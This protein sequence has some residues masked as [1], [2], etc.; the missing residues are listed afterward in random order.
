M[1]FS[2]HFPHFCL[3]LAENSCLVKKYCAVNQ[4]IMLLYAV[5]AVKTSFEFVFG[6]HYFLTNKL[7]INDLLLFS[8]LPFPPRL[9][10]GS[11]W[12]CIKAAWSKPVKNNCIKTIQFYIISVHIIIL[13]TP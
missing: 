12:Q 11:K 8:F 2:S 7:K 9:M 6:A 1:P 4:Y 13:F 10:P 5:T 3:A